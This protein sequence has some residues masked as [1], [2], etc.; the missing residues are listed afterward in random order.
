VLIVRDPDGAPAAPDPPTLV[1]DVSVKPLILLVW[2]GTLLTIAGTL[3]ALL[4]RR[5]DVASIPVI[6]VAQR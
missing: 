1:L 3:M 5:R 2:I 6:E 4:L